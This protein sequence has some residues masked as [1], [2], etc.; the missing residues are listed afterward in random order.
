MNR[1][2]YF[3]FLLLV[4]VTV[5][6]LSVVWEF[7]VEEQIPVDMLIVN[8]HES[9]DE[10]WRYVSSVAVFVLISLIFPALA[11]RRLIEHHERLIDRM[12][13]MAEDDYLTGL[14]NR[15]KG[16]ELLDYEFNR[17]RRYDS[18]FSV[19]ML[20][21]DYFKQTND[22]FGHSTGDQVLKGIAMLLRDDVRVADM[23]TR[24]GGEEFLIIC[25]ETDLEGAAQLA[26]KLRRRIEQYEFP[27]CGHKTV[28]FGVA[29][30]EKADATV[31]RL[32]ARADD[33]LYEAKNSGRNRVDVAYGS[34]LATG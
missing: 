17:S 2:Q 10:N 20:D 30:Y 31:E 5:V 18:R 33:A 23:V 3:L 7:W 13:R 9:S 25:P 24:W 4:F 1:R 34:S 29:A 26:E 19:I 14:Y 22:E 21:I 16:Q 6:M 11:G 15:R 8:R 27:V 12:Q 28:S 32:V